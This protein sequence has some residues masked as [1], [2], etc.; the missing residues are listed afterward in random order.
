MYTS[1]P[2]PARAQSVAL[3]AAAFTCATPASDEHEPGSAIDDTYARHSPGECRI[4]PVRR[5]VRGACGSH[6]SAH[7]LV[8]EAQWPG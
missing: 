3:D 7:V 8:K 4:S 1:G 2:G 5:C 6:G